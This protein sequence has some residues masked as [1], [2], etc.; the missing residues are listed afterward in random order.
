[1]PIPPLNA[2]S[3]TYENIDLYEHVKTSY[4]GICQSMGALLCVAKY[5]GCPCGWLNNA[6]WSMA[7]LWLVCMPVGALALLSWNLYAGSKR[8]EIDFQQNPGSSWGAFFKTVGAVKSEK[9]AETF[10][11]PKVIHGILKFILATVGTLLNLLGLK[12][13]MGYTSFGCEMTGGNLFLPEQDRRK[14]SWGKDES[15]AVSGPEMFIF[16]IAGT[17]LIVLSGLL[18]SK[19]GRGF[20][21]TLT[22]TLSKRIGVEYK[23]HAETLVIKAWHVVTPGIRGEPGEMGG[24]AKF[25]TFMADL[26]AKFNALTDPEIQKSLRNRGTW[27]RKNTYAMFYGEYNQNGMIWA[28]FL[29]LKACLTGIMLTSCEVSMCSVPCPCG[30]ANYTVTAPLL[31]LDGK[32]WTI[33]MMYVS[34]F[35]I[36]VFANPDCDLFNGYKMAFQQMQQV[37]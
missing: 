29:M 12:S 28:M 8:G 22:N 35:L 2:V 9:G 21:L 4:L 20:I 37:A 25:L 11:H 7:I 5:S 6:L 30:D 33:A 16:W 19:P 31:D 24:M 23:M 34:E 17:F 1:M 13:T 18:G 36:L 10:V 26:S 27:K 32:V 15:C 3:A 14:F